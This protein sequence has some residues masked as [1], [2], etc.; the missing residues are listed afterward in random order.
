MDKYENIPC[1]V[2]PPNLYRQ[3]YKHQLAM[4][5]KMEKLEQEQLVQDGNI[6]QRTKLG[7]NA[8]IAGH[9]KSATVVGLVLR[10]KME[11]DMEYPYAHE[12]TTTE[13][14]GLITRILVQRFDRL[15]STLILTSPSIVKQWQ[16]E[17]SY[18]DLIVKTVTT[19]RDIEEVHAEDC[20]VIIITPPMYNKF[21]MSYAKYAWKR[22]VFDEP[23]HVR[24]ASMRE[25][26]A[27]FYWFITSSP[28]S[29][30]AKHR[31]CRNSFIQEI[32]GDGWWDFDVQFSGM[33][34][35]NDDDFVRA[36]FNMPSTHFHDYEC[37]NP[38]LKAVN[39]IVN[40]HITDMLEAGNIEGVIYALGGKKT[41]NIVEL[42][43][44]NKQKELDDIIIKLKESETEELIRER[45]QLNKQ[46]SVL[47][48]RFREMLDSNCCICSEKLNGPVLEPRCQNMFCG[49]CL[50][51]WLQK[52]STCPLCREVIDTTQLVYLKDRK[53][54]L[55]VTGE[56]RMLTKNERVISIINTKEEGKF[57]IFS[58]SNETFGPICKLLS[59][60][61][62]PFAEVRGSVRSREKII[63]NFK[64]GD[65]KVLF[66]NSN[67][68]GAG[69][70]LQEATDLIL[71]HEMTI[72]KQN[73]VIGRA[74]RIGREEELHVHKLRVPV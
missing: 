27:G 31:N 37:F 68:D 64:N 39:G 74:N 54:T 45:E 65:L 69:L 4:I 20:N 57:L 10:D 17:F 21:V 58:S 5:F 66:L 46:L 44:K 42:V 43:R 53:D 25:L 1:V 35:K 49:N 72:C 36:S 41:E 56:P 3:L 24:I 67:N 18:T 13:S 12:T 47:D 34:L 23:G 38:L 9:G 11:W 26:R 50:L 29:I 19:T 61:K 52:S 70:N 22:F 16:D 7:V 6:I 2:Q 14:A 32:V 73:E 48:E 15:P 63:E 59:E 28:Q 51:T 71:Y 40:Q 8:D 30:S 62:I 33:I 55:Q 60:H